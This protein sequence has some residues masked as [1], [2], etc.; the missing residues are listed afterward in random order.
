MRSWLESTRSQ[1]PL[2]AS[3]SAWIARQSLAPDLSLDHRDDTDTFAQRTWS[4]VSRRSASVD[5]RKPSPIPIL[6]RFSIGGYR[7]CA[8]AQNKQC[9]VEPVS[10]ATLPLL[11]SASGL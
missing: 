8:G 9:R 3:R 5:S 6:P 7:R 4:Q 10:L 2:R 1:A 11:G